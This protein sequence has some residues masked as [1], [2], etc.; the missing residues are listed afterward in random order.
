VLR[1]K[2]FQL[3]IDIE[4]SKRKEPMPFSDYWNGP[5]HRQRADD[6]DIQLTDLQARYAQLQE[7]NR[8]IG[9]MDALEVQKLIE[10]E[11]GKLAAVRQVVQR[12]ERDVVALGQRSSDL[13]GQILVL[14][15]TLLLES[16]A[17]YEAKFKLNSSLEY[18]LRLDIIRDQQKR[19][20]K[21]GDAATGNMDWTVNGSK[22][23]GRK[24]VN[25]MI[26]LVIRSFNNEADFCVDNVKFNNV[27]LGEKRI[28]KSY[29]ACNRL[30]KIMDVELSRKYLSLKLDELHLAYEFQIK[31]QEEKEE[32]KRI[33][34]ELRE[35]QKLEQ[36]IRAA[37]EKIAKERRHFATA[38]RELQARLDKVATEEERALL[39]AKLAE[40]EAGRAELESEEKLI[41]YRE[42]NAKAGYVYVISNVG[43]FGEGVYKIGMTRRLEPMERIDELGDAS[44][45]FWFDVH[46]MVF[47]DNAPALEAKLHV[48]F[49]AGRLNKVN[50]RKEFFRADIAE[51]ES[52][53]RENYDAAA[54]FTHEA[55]AEQYRESL[56]MAMPTSAIQKS[57]IAAVKPSIADLV[58]VLDEP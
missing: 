30:G 52:V 51:I 10:Q 2:G 56:R 38:L 16:F 15:E 31:K 25:D 4:L 28:L 54:E 35:Q 7:F 47:S 57:E 14:G 40:V 5:A 42:Q 33:R 36:E 50:G 34:E 32:A 12:A 18:K 26:K 45:P 46:A 9:A 27:E 8:K 3:V 44:V 13:Q 43:A 1:Y 21:S 49:A 55:P 17:L 58:F 24:L 6:L 11:K 53:I 19:L 29:E 39:L 22:T 37:R 23:Q 48:R 20:I 41:D